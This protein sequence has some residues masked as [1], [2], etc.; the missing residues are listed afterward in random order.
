MDELL[1]NLR[2]ADAVKLEAKTPEPESLPVG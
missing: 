2:K 1:T